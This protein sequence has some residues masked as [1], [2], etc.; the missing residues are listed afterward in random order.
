M[1]CAGMNPIVIEQISGMRDVNLSYCQRQAWEKDRV[2]LRGYVNS[3]IRGV[4]IFDR[5][6][7]IGSSNKMCYSGIV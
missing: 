5:L 4:E 2:Q 1:F 7:K 6:G 3:K